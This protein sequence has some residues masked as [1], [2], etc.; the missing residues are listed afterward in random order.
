VSDPFELARAE[1]MMR[2][3]SAR[4]CDEPL[5]VLAVEAE[6]VADLLNPDTGSPSRTF[7]LGGKIDVIV[8]DEAGRVL[9]VEHKTS[10]EDVSAGS[11]YWKRLRLNGQISTYMVGAR[12]L[13]FEPVE[14]LYDVLAKPGQR[15]AS[16]PVIDE[17]GMKIVHDAQGLRVKTKD[18]KKWRETGDSKEGYVLQTRPETVDEYR[19]RVREAICKDPDKYFVRGTVVRLQDEEREASFD[20]WQTAANIR[21]GRRLNRHP[22]NPDSCL[23]YGAPCSMFEVCTGETSLEDLTRY[24]RVEN[25]HEELSASRRALP[26]L[27]NSEM[28]TYR[29]CARLHHYRYD[30]GARSLVD[31]D[32]ARFG[33]LIHRGLEQ[34]WT[35][36]KMLEDEHECLAR[37]FTAMREPPEEAP[38]STKERPQVTL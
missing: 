20:A 38:N 25:V 19:L 4:W 30:L 1:E 12:S 26:L 16:V 15:P 28:S 22:R 21:E 27:T 2:G 11:A 23:R 10:S 36:K 29:A 8:A 3:Y 5:T 32:A 35:G 6:F 9:N 24:R 31:A 17:W 37:A 33:T 13:G 7:Q 34:W 14:T 18:G